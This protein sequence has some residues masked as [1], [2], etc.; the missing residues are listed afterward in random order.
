GIGDDAA[1]LAPGSEP[2]VCSVDASVQ[3]VHFDLGLVGLA[4][5]GYRSFQAAVSD[6]AAM[7]ARPLA[8]LS[9]LVLP[10]ALSAADI[11]RLTAGQAEAS[12]ETGCPV[13]GGNVS[14]GGEL[15]ITTTV[16]GH[17][18]Q[19]ILRSGARPGDQVWLLGEL[20]LAAAGLS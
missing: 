14:R 1:V 7:G 3:G 4:D 2:W 12:R 9:A 19:P 20:G 5:V 11:D 18:A 8:A 15:G 17:A 13:V 6:L 10:R 16:L